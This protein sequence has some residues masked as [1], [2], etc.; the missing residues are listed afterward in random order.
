MTPDTGW[1]VVVALGNEAYEIHAR[2]GPMQ[3]LRLPPS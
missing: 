3:G 2:V 1:H